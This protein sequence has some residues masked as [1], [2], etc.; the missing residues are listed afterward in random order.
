[1]ERASPRGVPLP[2]ALRAPL[3]AVIF[4]VHGAGL[5]APSLALA[6]APDTYGFGSRGAAMGGAMAADASDFS[7]VHYNPAGLAGARGPS[8]SFGY[9]AIANQLS[10]SGASSAVPTVR[11]VGGGLVVPGMFLGLPVAFGVSAYVPDTGLSTIRAI[12]EETP[13]WELYDDR[14]SITMIAAAVAVRIAGVLDVGGGLGFLAATRGRFGIRGTANVSSPYE[15]KLE[16]TVDAD[17]TSIRYPLVGARLRL[18][19]GASVGFA[20]RGQAVLPLSLD[21]LLDGEVDV[22]LR[23]PLEYELSSRTNDGFVP[24][25]ATIGVSL[26]RW[27]FARGSDGPRFRLNLDASWVGWSQYASP[28]AQTDARLDVDVP[29]GIPLE[30][31]QSPK[32]T[33]PTPP[34]FRD[35]VV[36]RAGLEL[37]L[38]LTRERR[39]VF[40]ESRARVELP[41]RAG[42]VFEATPIPAQTGR[43]NFVDTDR[44]TFSVGVG[45]HFHDPFSVLH[46]ALTLDVHAQASWLPERATY[47]ANPADFVGDYRQGGAMFGGGATVGLHFDGWPTSAASPAKGA[48]P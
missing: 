35:R 3:C 44:H 16:H 43:T 19:E 14:L 20:Y 48:R 18:A 34:G 39:A 1:M 42:Y 27:P 32:P 12:R 46:G 45:A 2:P 6:H 28:T 24:Q 29:A 21:A 25:R 26:S 5:C 22:G 15:S 40:G 47:K 33:K 7:A 17:L 9:Q 8:L 13:R 11:G 37:T 10:I 30:L 36:P 23:V 38:P 31:P 41:L 4:A